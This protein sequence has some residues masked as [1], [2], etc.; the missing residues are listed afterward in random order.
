M[1][2]LAA[3]AILAAWAAW[4]GGWA[5][6]PCDWPVA[7]ALLAFGGFYGVP[8]VIGW[9]TGRFGHAWA[10]AGWAAVAAAAIRYVPRSAPPGWHPGLAVLGMLR[11]HWQAR[12]LW[13]GIAAILACL[14]VIGSRLPMRT[15]DAVGY[16]LQN[17]MRWG[18]DGVFQLDSFG[19]ARLDDY[20]G[21]A[22]TYA[23]VKAVFPALLI[24]ATGR[25][26]GTA[27]V[28]WPF[29][30]LALTAGYAMARRIGLGAG[31]AGVVAA[32][33]LGAPEVV[34]QSID[35]Y[36]DVV[37]WSGQMALAWI[38]LRAATESPSA[39]L[40]QLA[41]LAFA[42]LA[43][44]KPT[45][46]PQGA[47]IGACYLALIAA[48]SEPGRRWRNA[49]MALAWAVGVSLLIA[50]PWYLYA[51]W[52]FGNPIFPV[53]VKLGD[54]ALLAGPLP[55]GVNDHWV[56]L[57]TQ[58]EGWAAWWN[59]LR[60]EW[61]DPSLAS[62]SGGLGAHMFILGLPALL[63]A[64][65]AT[66]ANGEHRRVRLIALGTLL[67]MSLTTPSAVVAR[68]LLALLAAGGLAG[69]LLLQGAPV[70]PRRIG[71]VLLALL[72]AHNARRVAPA[73]L[74]RSRP[75]E[76]WVYGLASG[77]TGWI[78]HDCYPEDLSTL[79]WWR[80][81][82]AAPGKRL[83]FTR[84]YGAQ[85]VPEIPGA[86]AVNVMTLAEAGGDTEVWQQGLTEAGVSHLFLRRRD[87]DFEAAIAAPN[88]FRLVIRRV[89]SGATHPWSMAVQPDAGLFELLPPSD[90][91][92]SE[93]Q[94]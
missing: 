32:W 21:C 39:R 56:K 40:M 29:L 71:L 1:L 55:A 85:H 25:L 91:V 76:L 61:R 48:H 84:G 6:R 83:G 37:Y 75:P 22:E 80:E 59:T 94:P 69:A 15:W 60:E 89:D 7:T 78:T 3:Y 92:T 8:I 58:S 41:G 23:N 16:H 14:L 74:Y 82:I 35:G 36:A 9:V 54:S 26:D 30:L 53:E 17:P 51:L 47:L 65:G 67:A 43:G 64:F 79:D 70:W 66:I 12:L 87:V 62:W 18:R 38:I 31:G 10:W 52:H 77:H 73:L 13:V 28:Q 4:R 90:A 2:L 88:L 72:L 81:V 49:T 11:W 20:Q 42:V 33:C 24:A 63:L 5:V 27:V 50:G 86:D 44:A 68:F 19:P 34:L 46:L 45:G 93:A 57:Y